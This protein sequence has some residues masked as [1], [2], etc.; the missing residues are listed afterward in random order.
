M[1]TSPGT[2]EGAPG[3]VPRRAAAVL[4]VLT[5]ATPMGLALFDGATLVVTWTNRAYRQFLDEPHRSRGVVGLRLDEFA[6][7]ARVVPKLIARVVASGEPEAVE[8]VEY[9]GLG[10]GLTWWRASL[11]PVEGGPGRPRDVLLSLLDVTVQVEARRRAEALAG[12][13]RDAEQATWRSADR[14]R[15]LLEAT[16]ELAAARTAAEVAR[17]LFG[18]AVRPLGASTGVLFVP[19]GPGMLELVGV[20]G[21]EAREVEA[22]RRLPVSTPLPATAAA[23]RREAIWLETPAE[24][25]AAF[26]A[27][28][29]LPGRP[30]RSQALA[31]IP[32][33]AGGGDLQGV[34]GL[35]LRA[36]HHF[37]PSERAFLLSLA[38]QGALGIERA[39]LL[40]ALRREQARLALSQELTTALS[41]AHTV[42]E[43]AGAVFRQGLEAFGARAGMLALAREG[44]LRVEH[45]FGYGP[46]Q[47]QA[48]RS[49]DPAGPIPVAQAFRAGQPVW[50]ESRTELEERFPTLAGRLAPE[51]GAW[52]ALPLGGPEGPVGVLGLSFAGER[53]FEASERALAV[54]LSHKCAQALERAQLFESERAARAEAERASALQ[55]RLVA[56]VGHDL[57][58]PLS[59]IDMTAQALLRRG[60]LAA[61]EAASVT[62]IASS[63]ARMASIIRDLLDYSRTR[64]GQGIPVRPAPLDAD[65]LCRRVVGEIRQASP[66]ASI[67][68]LAE[69]D[70]RLMGDADRLQQVVAN[71]VANAVQ[72]GG[73]ERVEV[74]ARSD[75]DEVALSVHN[76]GPP[77]DPEVLPHLFEPF[78]RGR[79]ARPG[80][81]IGLGLYIVSE[82]V[83]AHGGRVE[84]ASAPGAGTTFTVRLPRG[85][86]AA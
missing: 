79:S 27:M 19:A 67:E 35:G 78:R 12:Q 53:T 48:F 49:I 38:E 40:E 1:A 69:G 31:A 62:R 43:V 17:A 81:S 39:R 72:H 15:R 18:G 28:A 16:A 42:A 68:L 9:R 85:A 83:K 84:V 52:A 71:L 44:M 80:D 76:S 51:H 86:G 77:I 56:V 64:Q 5:A 73:Q 29:Q 10:R 55:E 50:V 26:P 20:H 54:S 8:E 41:S 14:L 7:N 74:V 21:L 34:L 61:R 30:I 46:E 47:A 57:R 36:P 24:I 65:E 11:Q 59:A 58:T 3:G 4:E 82:I 32:L 25:E 70:L 37:E 13:S 60:G 45:L 66:E 75:G 23:A 63:A 22:Y 6:P 2:E 33:Q